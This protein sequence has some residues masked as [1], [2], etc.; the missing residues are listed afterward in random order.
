[1]KN[2]TIIIIL[3]ICF[4]TINSFGNDTKL[5]G[6]INT[7]YFIDRSN[8]KGEF[9]RI[10]VDIYIPRNNKIT[11]DILVLPGWKYSRIKWHRETDMTK[12]ADKFGFRLVFPD[13][14]VSSYESTYFPET[15]LMW[16][17][18]PGGVWIKHILLPELETKYGIFKKNGKNFILGLSTGGRGVLL[19]AL[20]NPDFFSGGATLSGD[21]DQ[22][23]MPGEKT[24]TVLYGDFTKFKSRW[25]TVDNPLKEIKAGKWQMPL[26]IGH[27]K[28]DK[29]SPFEQSK[30]LYDTLN[31][32]YPNLK[33][34]F[35]EPDWAEHDF[36]YWK[37]EVPNIMNFF[38]EII[39]AK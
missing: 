32:T 35:N 18:T 10:A 8:H 2:I 9:K 28:K 31:K 25:E 5:S 6:G 34:V 22:S 23:L 11:G 33:I 14:W 12:Y 21:C 36:I 30:L 26:Y 13:M 17:Y 1:M 7:I 37:S 3:L 29:V 16:A 24:M 4:Q 19:V 39:H 38:N 27:G 15:T 20:Q